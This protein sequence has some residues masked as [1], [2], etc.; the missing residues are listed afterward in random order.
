MS[1]CRHLNRGVRDGNS[2]PPRDAAAQRQG[3]GRTGTG[4]ALRH[5][6]QFRRR[7]VRSVPRFQGNASFVQA[8]TGRM[9]A[10]IETFS[11]SGGPV[12]VVGAKRESHSGCRAEKRRR[13][14]EAP[15]AERAP[16]RPFRACVLAAAT[17][18]HVA[19]EHHQLDGPV[20]FR[21]GGRREPSRTPRGVVRRGRRDPTGRPA[22]GR[23]NGPEKG[24][25]LSLQLGFKAGDYPKHA[26]LAVR[27]GQGASDCRRHGI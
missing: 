20:Q 8:G 10:T 26:G 18:Q 5:G 4:P 24:Q 23:R 7:F 12:L 14:G 21:R 11:P 6:F 15:S 27:G 2:P 3:T 9:Q 17:R 1:A 16:R 25:Q 22:G 13:G 19:P